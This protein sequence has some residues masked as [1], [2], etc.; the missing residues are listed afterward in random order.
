MPVQ[1]SHAAPAPAVPQGGQTSTPAQAQTPSESVQVEH[2][3][4]QAIRAISE[5]V[6]RAI[7]LDLKLERERRG[8]TKWR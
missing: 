4:P 3:S 2:L 8:I 1:A 7:T 5:R 6:I